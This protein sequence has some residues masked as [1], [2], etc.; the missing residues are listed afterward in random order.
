MAKLV[1]SKSFIY[2]FKRTLDLRGSHRW[3][4]IYENALK[5][6]S[7]LRGDWNYVG[8]AISTSAKKIGKQEGISIKFKTKQK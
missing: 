3:P 7:A 5:D 1:V 6:A 2:G 8:E 4:N